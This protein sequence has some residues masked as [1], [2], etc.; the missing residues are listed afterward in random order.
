MEKE[1]RFHYHHFPLTSF[2]HI[3]SSTVHAGAESL[4]HTP[5]G[6]SR[7]TFLLTLE[8]RKCS[9]VVLW[10]K[11]ELPSFLH[12]R[13]ATGDPDSCHMC[14]SVFNVWLQLTTQNKP[15]LH[16]NPVMAGTPERQ[17]GR[18]SETG[19]CFSSLVCICDTVYVCLCVSL[20]FNVPFMHKHRC[21]VCSVSLSWRQCISSEPGPAEVA[22][23]VHSQCAF[24]PAVPIYTVCH[25][26]VLDRN[27]YRAPCF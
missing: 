4:Y 11:S 15:K 6:A 26:T 23:C 21:T 10:S 9:N 14:L 22:C 2:K 25:L 1:V 8:R 20:L 19:A 24:L 3:F 27:I 17:T 13:I 7:D 18:Q 12:S 5:H 16:F